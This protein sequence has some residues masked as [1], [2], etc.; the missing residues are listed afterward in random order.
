MLLFV[1]D[2]FIYFYFLTIVLLILF[3]QLF[4]FF[5][6]YSFYGFSYTNFVTCSLKIKNKHHKTIILGIITFI[7]LWL[8]GHHII[9]S[10]DKY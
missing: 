4:I 10:N 5:F 9:H 7:G 6:G 3:F 2:V 1:V 8:A